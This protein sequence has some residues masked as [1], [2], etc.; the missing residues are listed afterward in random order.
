MLTDHAAQLLGLACALPG[1]LAFVA[2]F[3]AAFFRNW[4]DQLADRA[5]DRSE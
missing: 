3:A 2:F 1:A 5:A 4:I